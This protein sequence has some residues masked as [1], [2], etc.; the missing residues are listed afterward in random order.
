MLGKVVAALNMVTTSERLQ[1]DV[2]QRDLLPLLLYA[3][4]ELQP[5]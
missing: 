2:M 5:L 3:S 1:S 4:R